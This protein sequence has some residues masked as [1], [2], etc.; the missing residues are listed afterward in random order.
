MD[1]IYKMEA[2][3]YLFGI[4]AASIIRTLD[5]ESFLEGYMEDETVLI[6]LA[7]FF[8]QSTALLPQSEFVVVEM[9]TRTEPLVLLV[10]SI[11]GEVVSPEQ[12]TSL[13]SFYPE[14][15]RRCCPHIMIH[16]EQPVLL[17]DGTGL[18][19]VREMLENSYGVIFMDTLCEEKHSN[20]MEGESSIPHR[21]TPIPQ[22]QAAVEFDDALFHTIVSWTIS[23][24]LDHGERGK[25]TV[26]VDALPVEYIHSIQLLGM[27]INTLQNLIDKTVL[28]CGKFNNAALVRLRDKATG[29]QL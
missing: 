22:Q 12:L 18:A 1:K 23:R 13:P 17:L 2:G 7:S 3:D 25:C 16:D 14:L 4:D 21:G 9:K 11:V 10:D 15:A 20:G 29:K 26:T 5:R 28:K 24:Y 8:N 6:S 19:E 27:N